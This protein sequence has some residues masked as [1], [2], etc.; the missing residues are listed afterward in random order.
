MNQDRLQR[1]KE[2]FADAMEVLSEQHERIREDL[3]FSNPAKPEQWTTQAIQLRQARPIMTFNRVPKFIRQVSNDGRSSIPSF[4]VTPADSF[5]HA[6]AAEVINARI[7]HIEYVSKAKVAYST[8]LELSANCGL[9]WLRVVPAV[10]NDETNQQEPRILRVHDPL[11]CVIDTDATEPDGSDAEWGFVLSPL[12]K[13]KFKRTFPKSEITYGWSDERNLWTSA[14]SV[15]VAEYFERVKKKVSKIM[16]ATPDGET[17]ALTE[18]EFWQVADEIGVKPEVTGTFVAEESKVVWSKMTGCEELEVTDFPSKF[19]PIVPVVGDEVWVDGK[20]YICGLTRQLMD[21]Q[22]MHNAEMSSY[23]ENI[24]AQP[25]AP[26][27]VPIEGIRGHEESWKKLNTGN[28]AFLPYNSLDDDGK[29]IPS[30]TR[31]NPPQIPN[32]FAQ[33]AMM[34]IGE[35]EASVG[36]AKSAFG[37]QSNAVSGRAKI[38]DRRQSDTGTYHYHDNL[39]RAVE[40]L[41]R[42]VFDMDRRLT[43][44]ARTV[45]TMSEDGKSSM[46]RF[47]PQMAESVRIRNGEVD[48]VNPAVGEYDM[49]VKVGASFITQSEETASELSEM[50]RGAPELLPVLG[51]TWVRLKGI[52]GGDKVAKLLLAMAPDAVKQI[53]AEDESEEKMPAQARMAIQRLEVQVQELSAALES[54]ASEADKTRVEEGKAHAEQEKAEADMLTKGYQAV[55]DRIKALV[56]GLTPEQVFMLAQVTFGQAMTIPP[57]D[58]ETPAAVGEASPN[59]QLPVN[60]DTLL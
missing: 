47:D 21:G 17:I 30:P 39:A 32:A 34:A 60:G 40:Q 38:E 52:P 12:S 41:G 9:G 44:T 22:R 57:I 56:P 14:D 2:R 28:P 58:D 6:K 55:T 37:E 42:I 18:S 26:F 19:I 15:L 49:R 3:R 43:D 8:A 36:M 16:I 23:T 29:Q 50:F 35:M 59:N 45:R 1:A 53:E 4:Q 13:A 51:P 10:I 48:A 7:R 46:I 24:L 20:R 31:M 27:A 54:A 5:A 33:G 11:S 25:K